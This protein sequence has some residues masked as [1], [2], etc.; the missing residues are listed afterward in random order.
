MTTPAKGNDFKKTAFQFAL[1]FLGGMYLVFILAIFI[2]FPKGYFPEALGMALLLMVFSFLNGTILLGAAA[3]A[4]LGIICAKWFLNIKNR[5]PVLPEKNVKRIKLLFC[6]SLLILGVFSLVPIYH[7]V[8]RLTTPKEQIWDVDTDG[9]G[10]TDKWVHID[11]F[12]KLC[13]IDYDTDGDGKPDLFEYY[14]K[15]GKLKQRTR[16]ILKR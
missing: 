9:N 16:E 13:E 8:G 10:R 5:L 15:Q 3:A 12:E 1:C 4:I 2:P 6:S 14:D 11:R 7:F